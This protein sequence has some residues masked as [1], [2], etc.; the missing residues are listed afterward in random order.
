LCLQGMKRENNVWQKTDH[1]SAQDFYIKMRRIDDTKNLTN[2]LSTDGVTVK[3]LREM[4]AAMITK[5]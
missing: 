5:I 2:L 1:S 3:H 4:T